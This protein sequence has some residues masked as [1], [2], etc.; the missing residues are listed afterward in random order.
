MPGA[1]CD[2]DLRQVIKPWFARN[3]DPDVHPA[4]HIGAPDTTSRS[5]RHTSESNM[6]TSFL[7]LSAALVLA[8]CDDAAETTAPGSRS[9]VSP[10]VAQVS[11]TQNASGKPAP[12]FTTVTSVE[13]GQG[14]FGG[15]GNVIGWLTSGTIT[16]TCPAGT[17]VIGGHR[18]VSVEEKGA[19]GA[20]SRRPRMRTRPT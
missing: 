11:P 5:Q 17:Q 1:K 10:S 12:E 15:A 20:G 6:R 16:M 4:R 19:A 18:G 8:A 14:I 13:S 7:L 2:N 3:R 9:I